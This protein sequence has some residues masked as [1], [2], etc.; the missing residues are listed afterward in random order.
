M[1]MQD[2]IKVK[3]ISYK[4]YEELLVKKDK[5][6]KEAE[7]YRF[8]YEQIFGSLN[9]EI[10]DIKMECVKKRKTLSYC[11]NVVNLGL[12][13]YRKELDDFIEN[14]MKDYQDT[15]ACLMNDDSS[16]TQK[17]ASPKEIK[18]IYRGIAK[19]IHPDMNEQ[20]K[21]DEVVQDLWNRTCIAYNCTNYKDLLEL[22]V[23]VNKYLESIF[24]DH[25]DDIVIPNIEEKIFDLY[26]EIENIKQTNPYQYKYILMDENNIISKIDE[27][28]KEIND[29]KRYNEDLDNQI[30]DY[31]PLI[32][33]GEKA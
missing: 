29:Y 18:R 27:L 15:I 26:K 2:V 3:S 12:P 32:N 6:L 22:E 24:Y 21:S 31:E 30:K 23:L 19:L 1:L 14:A 5:L 16:E 8:S 33:D 11:K 9:K 25:N 10:S 20:L 7:K 13:I 4:R 17:S 28:S